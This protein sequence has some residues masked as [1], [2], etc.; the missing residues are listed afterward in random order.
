MERLKNPGTILSVVSLVLLILTQAGVAYDNENVMAIVKLV[1]SI[2]ITL[3]ILNNPT[4]PG[5]DNPIK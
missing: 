2:G 1:L 4:T 5:L 3:G